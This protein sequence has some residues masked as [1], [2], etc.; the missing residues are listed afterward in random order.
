[1]IKEWNLNKDWRFYLGEEPR[2][3]QMSHAQA[4]QYA[5]AGSVNGFGGIN[6]DDSDWDIVELPHDYMVQTGFY[7]DEIRSHGYRK[8]EN[9]WY[10]K[11]FLL[12]EEY[13]GK[14]QK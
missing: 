6:C 7:A 9:A 10:R 13:K 11:R 2:P 3:K 4:Y 12:P 14:Q 1:M 5:H 8:P